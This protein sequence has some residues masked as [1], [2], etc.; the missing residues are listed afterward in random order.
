MFDET[1]EVLSSGLNGSKGAKDGMLTFNDAKDE[2]YLDF[3]MDGSNCSVWNQTLLFNGTNYTC[4]AVL[5][6]EEY[7]YSMPI[8]RQVMWMILFVSMATVATCGNLIVIWIVMS[9]QRMRTVTNYFIGRTP[10]VPMVC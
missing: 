9:H 5:E 6:M 2:D 10:I 8:W 1:G 4:G 7:S 3:V